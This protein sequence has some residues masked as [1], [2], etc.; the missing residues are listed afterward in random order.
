[1]Q[2]VISVSAVRFS[3]G[4][5]YGGSTSLFFWRLF[6][7]AVAEDTVDSLMELALVF[8]GICTYCTTVPSC[9]IYTGLK[10]T[11]VR[12]LWHWHLWFTV[13]LILSNFMAVGT[14][15]LYL[16]RLCG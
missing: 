1:M 2:T 4:S 5:V 15:I 16:T 8:C 14:A 9:C 6:L 12:H 3:A 7:G 11:G 13:S 10:R